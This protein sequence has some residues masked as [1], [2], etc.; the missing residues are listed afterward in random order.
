VLVASRAFER[1]DLSPDASA[2]PVSSSQP[3]LPLFRA[4]AVVKALFTL[5]LYPMVL[6]YVTGSN[7]VESS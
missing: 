6:G 4:G 5:G 3:D 7:E 2:F 1:L